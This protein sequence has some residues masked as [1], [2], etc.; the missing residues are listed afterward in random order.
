MERMKW[1]SRCG[2]TCAIGPHPFRSGMHGYLFF[3][4]LPTSSNTITIAIS[5]PLPAKASYKRLAVQ[6][7]LH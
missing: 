3:Y 4:S 1:R 2:T 6:A 7:I 5:H